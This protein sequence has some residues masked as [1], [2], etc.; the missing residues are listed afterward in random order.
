MNPNCLSVAAFRINDPTIEALQ[1]I[2]KDDPK[3]LLLER[4]ELVGMLSQWEMQGHEMDRAFYLEAHTGLRGY[5]GARIVRGEFSIPILCLSLFGG[6][7][8]IK[9]VQ[10]LRDPK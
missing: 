7:Q 10:Y 3:C 5:S 9:L 2:L 4:D 1:D 6:I 8:P